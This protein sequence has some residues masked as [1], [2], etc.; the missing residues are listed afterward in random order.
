MTLNALNATNAYQNQLK[1]MQDAPDSGNSGGSGAAGDSS[2][3]QMVEKAAKDAADTG[4]QSEALQMSSLTGGKVELSD[5]VTA[6][7]NAQLS[8]ETVVAVRDRVINAYQD[9]IKMS[10]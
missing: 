5:L 9:I 2:F 7:S 6:V 3:I 4:Y 1:L 8:L 10:I